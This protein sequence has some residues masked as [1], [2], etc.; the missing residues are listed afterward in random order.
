MKE[1]FVYGPLTRQGA[2]KYDTVIEI[3]GS[4]SPEL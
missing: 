1:G 3:L 2:W 4:D